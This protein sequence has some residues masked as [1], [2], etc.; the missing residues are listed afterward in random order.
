MNNPQTTIFYGYA[1]DPIVWGTCRVRVM[2]TDDYLFEGT[3]DACQEWIKTRVNSSWK[4]IWAD[5]RALWQRSDGMIQV[6]CMLTDEEHLV[7][8]DQFNVIEYRRI[9]GTEFDSGKSRL[10]LDVTMKL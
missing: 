9:P 10:M 6:N 3:L 2:N 4:P 5:N 7:S 8:P 1:I